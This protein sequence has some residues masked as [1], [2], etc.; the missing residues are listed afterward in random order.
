M[1]YHF[2]AIIFA[3]LCLLSSTGYAQFA[4]SGEFRPR[5]EY[6]H[7]FKKLAATPGAHA[8]FTEQRTR[9]KFG[10]QQEK[11]SFGLTLQDVRIWG[12]TGQINKADRLTSVHEAWGG[13]QLSGQWLL[14]LGRQELVY[15]DHRIMGSLDW[16]A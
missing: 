1:P 12:E 13:I 4:L 7:G 14:K 10:Y 2:R 3:S 9:L 16:A 15:D 8:L 6:G 5:T 11:L